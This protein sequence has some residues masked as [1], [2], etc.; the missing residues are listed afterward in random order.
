VHSRRS[1]RWLELLTRHEEKRDE[2]PLVV[3]PLEDTDLPKD[4]E[5]K[6]ALRRRLGLPEDRF[7]FVSP[8][9]FFA[10]KR[11]KE[12]IRALPDDA[13]LV[14]SGTKSDWEPR[15]FDEVM[16]VARDKPNVVINTDYD[17]MG[18]YVA[19]S[20]C[21][22]LFYEDVFQSAVV[23]QAVWAGL[24]CIFSDA[25]GFAPYRGAG[26]VARDTGE[27]AEAMREIQQPEAHARIVRSVKIL[28]R[29]LSPERNAERYIAGI[30][31][32]H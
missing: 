7:V 28:R 4:A 27:L 22:V 14:L 19:A 8:G 6:R 20:D 17:T 29:L 30:S 18:D 15:Y 11:Y 24:P 25:E 1:A 31:V 5:E 21:V 32:R 3:M 26:L 13:T 9:F 2:F 23:T 10:R 12:V 16:D